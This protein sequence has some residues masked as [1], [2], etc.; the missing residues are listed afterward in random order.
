MCFWPKADQIA[1]MNQRVLMN[2]SA[3]G[4]RPA[5]TQAIPTVAQ[6]L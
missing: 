4:D 6:Y 5:L 3:G 2:N 1:L